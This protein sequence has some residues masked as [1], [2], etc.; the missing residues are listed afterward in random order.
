MTTTGPDLT[1]P[2]QGGPGRSSRPVPDPTGPRGTQGHS[3]PVVSGEVD[4]ELRAAVDERLKERLAAARR[5]REEREQARREKD[6]RRAAGLRQ[7]HARKLAR[8]RRTDD[9]D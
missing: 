8:M 9:Q 1:G 4:R 6:V 2:L 7:R 3:G 5:R